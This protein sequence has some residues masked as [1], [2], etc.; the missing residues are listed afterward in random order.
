MINGKGGGRSDFAQAGGE[1]IADP[2]GL[3][4]KID[5]VLTGHNED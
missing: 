3:K 2:E 4:K 1:P 5:R